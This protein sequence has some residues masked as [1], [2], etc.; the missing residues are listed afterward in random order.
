MSV[1]S[2]LTRIFGGKLCSTLHAPNRSDT[3]T[4]EDWRSL[5]ID[6]Q[7]R[8]P[9]SHSSHSTHT[10]HVLQKHDSV[11]SIEDALA[12]ISHLQPV[13][14]GPSGLSE[15][16][17]QV[18]IEVLPSVLVLHL[19]R[20]LYDAA[21]DGIVKIS[22]PVQFAPELEIPLGTKFS[23]VSPMLV[24]AKNRSWHCLS[25]NHDTRFREICGTGA[26]QAL[27]GT[28]PSWRVGSKRALYSRRAAP[29]RRQ[30]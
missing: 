22:K 15:A 25:R 2:P 18:L 12:R 29:E 10:H 8:F 24:K 16:S 3:V 17:Q 9:S 28:L 19:K 6:I 11:F 13:Q 7:V 20:F 5:Q 21:A 27:W 26:I 14:L 1:E 4:I 30:W 23:F